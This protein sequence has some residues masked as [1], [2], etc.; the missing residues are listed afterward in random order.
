MQIRLRAESAPSFQLLEPRAMPALLDRVLRL[1][2]HDRNNTLL[3]V[4]PLHKMNSSFS[5]CKA[6]LADDAGAGQD[7]GR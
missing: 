2:P 4:S 5:L 1:Y 6:V 3:N 7:Q